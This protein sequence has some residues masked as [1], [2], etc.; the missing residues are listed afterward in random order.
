MTFSPKDLFKALKNNTKNLCKNLVNQFSDNIPSS[1]NKAVFVLVTVLSLSLVSVSSNSLG[2]MRSVINSNFSSK[3]NLSSVP[4]QLLNSNNNINGVEFASN[5]VTIASSSSSSVE[6]FSQSS[7]ESSIA[8]TES[9]SSSSSVEIKAASV[10]ISS[11]SAKPKLVV[12]SSSIEIPKE[13]I[14]ETPKESPEPELAEKVNEE[15]SA[16]ESQAVITEQVQSEPAPIIESLPKPKTNYELIKINCEK[17]GCNADRL[18]RV[19]ICESGGRSNAYGPGGYIGL[20]QFAPSSFWN[21][22]RLSGI[23]VSDIYN[24]EQQIQLAAWMYS[25]G[26]A[27][28]W[29]NC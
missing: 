1:L 26:Y 14:K 12:S 13:I 6:S 17:Y 25:N 16:T 24:A 20:F 18:N 28:S 27:G 22:S 23:P 9:S 5:M 7:S 4:A 21:Y 8:I 10:I 19:M 15:S 2:G 3:V 11:S 29:P